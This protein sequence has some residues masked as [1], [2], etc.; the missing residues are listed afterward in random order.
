MESLN[1]PKSEPHIRPLWLSQES[2]S[3][4]P[5]TCCPLVKEP[6]KTTVGPVITRVQKCTDPVVPVIQRSTKEK[7]TINGRTHSLPTTK[8]YLLQEC[9]D[10]QHP[11]H[12][13]A[14][15]LKPL[16]KAELERLTQ[17]G[18]IKEVREHTEWINLIVP[19]KKLDGS[20]WLCLDPKDLYWVIKRNQ[21][22][23]KT[24]ND[25]LPELADSKYFSLL[26]MK[27]HSSWE[28]AQQSP[29]NYPRGSFWFW[30]DATR[31]L[32]SS[33]LARNN[34]RFTT[35]STGLW[36]V[37]DVLEEPTTRDTV[38]PWSSSRTLGE[39]RNWFLRVSVYYLP[40][41][42]RLLLTV[43]FL[44]FGK[45]TAPTRALPPRF[46]RKCL[47]NM[48]CLKPLW[49]TTAPYSRRRNMQPLQTNTALTTSHQALVT[50][51]VMVS[52]N[53]W[54]RQSSSVW[55]NVQLQ[56]MIQA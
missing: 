21:W 26:D 41:D 3:R 4:N 40:P 5:E 14:V 34:L 15:S 46:W 47:A 52:L 20:L 53:V 51:R 35:G 11:P 13:V 18:V 1:H 39:V 29:P 27:A 50:C 32:R 43:G 44:W 8:D 42:S 16:Y 24:V 33:I 31:S 17:L 9:A 25:I 54:G 56:D 45:Y 22:Y 7:I 48:E 49:Q 36:S 2:S 55:G 28:I 12:Q 6:A 10:V 30:E 23:S 38:A 19:V 37:P